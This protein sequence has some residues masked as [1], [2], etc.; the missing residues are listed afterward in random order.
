MKAKSQLRAKQLPRFVTI[1][2]AVTAIFS[3][4]LATLSRAQTEKRLTRETSGA[5]PASGI[6]KPE[7]KTSS[8]ASDRYRRGSA[9]FRDQDKANLGDER[10][11]EHTSELH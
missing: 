3:I 9:R 11:E 4:A 10:S 6:G 8:R 5:K 1:L 2:V 7:K